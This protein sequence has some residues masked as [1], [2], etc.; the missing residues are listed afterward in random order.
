LNSNE[1]ERIG[2]NGGF[3][4]A[5]GADCNLSIAFTILS[6]VAGNQVKENKL[7]LICGTNEQTN[8][9]TNW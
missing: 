9:H 3:C 8:K 1:K 5:L 7:V 4:K 6:P 2:C